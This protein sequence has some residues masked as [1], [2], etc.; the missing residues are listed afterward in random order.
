MKVFW[1]CFPLIASLFKKHGST[2]K[3]NIC[4]CSF[5]FYFT[6]STWLGK[7]IFSSSLRTYLKRSWGGGLWGVFFSSSCAWITE[8][9]LCFSSWKILALILFTENWWKH[10]SSPFCAFFN[11][12]N[13]VYRK[14]IT[15]ETFCKLKHIHTDK[16]VL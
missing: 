9:L 2:V 16:A 11:F 5:T 3:P 4:M 7:L 1:F 13:H 8:H 10:F 15:R 14:N 12:A 6:W